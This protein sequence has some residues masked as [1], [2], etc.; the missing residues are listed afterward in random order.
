MYRE[1]TLSVNGRMNV[2]LILSLLFDFVK[3][4]NSQRASNGTFS[5]MS[6]LENRQQPTACLRRINNTLSGNFTYTQTS[7]Y[8]HFTSQTVMT[9]SPSYQLDNFAVQ[10]KFYYAHT[11]SF[12]IFTNLKC[13][14]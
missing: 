11:L 12:A 6:A 13:A 7:L 4:L 3:S 5:T 10:R 2:H 9:R 8:N 1:L 14:K